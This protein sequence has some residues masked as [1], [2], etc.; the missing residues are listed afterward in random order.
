MSNQPSAI[1]IQLE[2]ERQEY[3]LSIK[4]KDAWDRYAESCRHPLLNEDR[5]QQ[6]SD[7]NCVVDLLLLPHKLTARIKHLPGEEQM[8]LMALH[9]A[10]RQANGKKTQYKRLALG[11][12]IKNPYIIDN[13][14]FQPKRAEI[15]EMFGRYYSVQE[16][17]KVITVDWGYECAMSSLEVF[18]TK[19]IDKIKELQEAFKRDYSDIRLG[20]KRSRLDE[21]SFLY[22][23]RKQRYKLSGGRE[24]YKLLLVTI[25]Q[26]RK[27]VEGDTIRIDGNLNINIQAT[28]N[29]HIFQ[30]M[31]A[32]LS[33]IDVVISKICAKNN[34]NPQ[35]LMT[36][37]RSSMYAR[38]TG[39]QA[40]PAQDNQEEITYPSQLIYDF[41]RIERMHQGKS[42]EE[43]LNKQRLSAI[44]ADII[45]EDKAI[46][47]ARN[48]RAEILARI[49]KKKTNV[50]VSLDNL[51]QQNVA[52]QKEGDEKIAKDVV[53]QKFIKDSQRNLK[54]AREHYKAPPK[55]KK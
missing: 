20:H 24:D 14:I 49:S 50:T 4:D 34:F 42:R 23:D 36:K 18:R 46:T 38:L 31:L 10:A 44:D 22:N 1:D 35:Y 48:T 27:E 13:D 11:N 40:T 15:L 21:L 45:L 26:I 9:T 41:S 43:E 16:V 19:N 6:T 51:D 55:K 53:K 30:E 5:I 3:A 37:L 33:I 2:N 47:K 32:D 8:K 17:H 29:F 39:F 52:K 12:G 54:S 25:E 28:L 7:V